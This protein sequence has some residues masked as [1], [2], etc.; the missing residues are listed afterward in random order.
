MLNARRLIVAGLVLATVI[1]AAAAVLA[2]LPGGA[3]TAR[4]TSGAGT[5]ASH[6]GPRGAPDGQG[7]SPRIPAAQGTTLEAPPPTTTD[8]H[9]G[10]PASKPAVPLFG[11]PVPPSATATGSRVH[12]FPSVIP[13]APQSVIST[14]SVA[15]TGGVLQ[16]ALDAKSA[17]APVD[18]IA[19]Y[20][21]ALAKHGLLGDP[22][23]AVGGS[24]ALSFARGDD[25][26]TLTV[27]PAKG[28]GS[29]YTIL[30]VFRTAG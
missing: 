7:T 27:T 4:S 15:S 12:G 16:A 29:H 10:L 3:P 6:V 13:L 9:S 20:R 11:G 17:V 28:G 21:S 19:F 25:S 30:A 23:P 22:L 26:I 5:P 8:V 2:V 24:T 18:A 14:S 1:A